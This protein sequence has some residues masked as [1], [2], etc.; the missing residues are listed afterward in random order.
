MSVLVTGAAGFLP[1]H[2]VRSLLDDGARVVGVDTFI[3]SDR[4]DL[5]P[6]LRDPRFDFYEMDVSTPGFRTFAE[7]LRP[8]AIYHLACPTGVPN[9][10]PLALEMM[11]ASYEGSRAVLEAARAERV[12]VAFASSAEVY[13][14]PEVSPQREDYNGN[15]NPLGAR[16]GYEGGKRVGETLFGIYAE[17]YGVPAKIV[18]VFNTYGPGM[19]LDETR[20]IPFFVK[21]ALLGRPITVHGD[22]LQTRCHTY[23]SDMVAAFRLIMAEGV[24]G[25]PYNVGSETP[26][27][28]KTLAELVIELTGSSSRVEHVPALSH[29]HRHRLPDTTRVRTELGWRQIVGLRDGLERTIADIRARLS[30]MR[31]DHASVA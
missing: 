10:G 22:G 12:P 9:N 6:L 26:V 17:R 21:S 15:V 14:D 7:K 2:I 5:A 30:Q 31:D 3:T 1:R 27:T 4:R 28:V 13:G 16:K 29:D 23:V 24:P 19:C 25:R 11:T 18:R 20:V 8:S